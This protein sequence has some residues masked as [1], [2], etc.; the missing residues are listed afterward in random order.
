MIAI[1]LHDLGK[2]GDIFCYVFNDLEVCFLLMEPGNNLVVLQKQIN[3]VIRI[4]S[5]NLLI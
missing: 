1:V 5:L 4:G 3:F 2:M